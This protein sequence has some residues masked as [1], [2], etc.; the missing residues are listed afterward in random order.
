MR[1]AGWWWVGVKPLKRQKNR[2]S[3]RCCLGKE[4]GSIRVGALAAPLA[5]RPAPQED[6]GD[7]E[8]EWCEKPLC[9]SGVRA[10]DVLASFCPS[11]RALLSGAPAAER[12]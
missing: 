10:G 7:V 1:S 4:P 3:A 5:R 6:G 9:C 12:T 8:R 2:L 11:R